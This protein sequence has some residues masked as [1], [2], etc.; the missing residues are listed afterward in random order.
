VRVGAGFAGVDVLGYHTYSASATWLTSAPANVSRPN[1]AAPDW[2]AYY[3]YARWRPTF[4]VSAS[5]ATSFFAG[6]ATDAGVPANETLRA[7]EFQAGVLLPIR[8]V[9]T[10]HVAVVSIDSE[11][12][13]YELADERLTVSRR[14]LRAG[15]AST[16]AHT[17]GYSI[18]PERGVT[19]GATVER[20]P[21]WLGSSGE[22]TAVTADARAYL[23]G[24]A[25]HHVVALRMAGG[26]STGD[27]DLRRSFHLGGAD[28]DG[29]VVD[30]GRGAISLLRGFA[31]DTFAGS[32]VAL[33]NADYRWPIARPQRGIGTW[34]IFLHTLHAAVFADAGHAWTRTFR[35]S[36]VKTSTGGELSAD[37]VAGYFFRFTLA[38]GAAWGHD[39]SGLVRDG[40]VAY[41]RVGKA[42]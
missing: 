7:R 34:P 25:P 14:A 1:A 4:W 33:L 8:H 21:S 20:V 22:A 32:H 19:T 28:P 2:D 38:G 16:T 30:F 24:A 39:G 42:F 35:A 18:S 17:Y 13:D 9:R 12:D 29:S 41:L 27:P 26:V 11:T 15:W 31:A 40:A 36:A 6:R 5:A 10:S 37:I 23:P 3:A